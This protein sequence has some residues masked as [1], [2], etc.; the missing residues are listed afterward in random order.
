MSCEDWAALAQAKEERLSCIRRFVAL[1]EGKGLGQK[2]VQRRSTFWLLKA[3]DH[4]LTLVTGRGMEAYVQSKCILD[5]VPE[6]ARVVV[7]S[8][9]SEVPRAMTWMA[10]QA[11]QGLSAWAFLANHL[12][13][14]SFLLPDPPHRFW[15]SEK[16][17][18]LQGDGWEVISLLTLVF[19]IAHGPWK[20]QKWL[21]E[22]SAAHQEYF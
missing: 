13:L 21:S 16:L 17:G 19:N 11:G 6:P 2:K 10:D 9:F 7:G 4:A 14:S 12:G 3:L 20:T 15:N 5:I 1:E 8:C 22:L 18:L